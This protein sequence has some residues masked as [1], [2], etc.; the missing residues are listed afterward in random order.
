MTSDSG[1]GAKA[2]HQGSDGGW[3]GAGG[4]ALLMSWG[5]TRL[6]WSL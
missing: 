6:P 4:G 2:G 1:V 3:G 5:G